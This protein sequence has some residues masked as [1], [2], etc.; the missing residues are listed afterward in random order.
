MYLK[1]FYVVHVDYLQIKVIRTIA[2]RLITYICDAAYLGPQGIGPQILVDADLGS[3][4]CSLAP[5]CM[6]S[7][8][9]SS[10]LLSKC[11]D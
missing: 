7:V 1:K 2:N 4:A 5:T 3:F 6:T 10:I 9:S 11:K 8:S